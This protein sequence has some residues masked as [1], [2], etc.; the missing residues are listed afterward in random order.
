MTVRMAGTQPVLPMAL[1]L[2]SARVP[3]TSDAE[4]RVVTSSVS[5]RRTHR[6][7]S[8]TCGTSVNFAVQ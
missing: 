7:K 5:F 2:N 3:S 6:M 8:M 1:G 4:S